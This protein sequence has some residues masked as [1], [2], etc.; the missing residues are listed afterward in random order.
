MSFFRPVALRWGLAVSATVGG[1]CHG[2]GGA[3]AAGIRLSASAA[4][5]AAAPTSGDHKR[6]ADLPGIKHMVA[7]SSCK[8]G[9]GKST[10]SVNLAVAFAKQGLR[11]GLLDA[12][13]FGP[14]LPRMMNLRGRPLVDKDKNMVPLLNY[15]VKC[16]SMGFLMEEDAAAVWRGPMVMGAVEKLL[17]GVAWGELDVLVVDMP[18]GTGD[19][20]ISMSQRARLSGV[21]VVTTPQEVALADVIRGVDMWEKVNVPILGVLETMSPHACVCCGTEAPIFGEGGGRRMAERM[22]IELLGEVPLAVEVRESADGGVPLVEAAPDS[23]GATVMKEVAAKIWQQLEDK[24]STAVGGG[25]PDIRM[26]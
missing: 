15:S 17:H 19:T 3:P 16:M 23:P 24:P 9:V 5:A 14:S 12:D 21:V 26:S 25:A 4:A 8:G 6:G 20:Q 2:A 18:P 7:V 10:S 22:G 13:V 11:V 1:G